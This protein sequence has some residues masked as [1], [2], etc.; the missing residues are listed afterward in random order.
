MRFFTTFSLFGALV[1][2]LPALSPEHIEAIR[3][4]NL[5][6]DSTRALETRQS[7]NVRN[8]LQAGGMCPPVI[9][10]WARGSTEEGNMVCDLEHRTV[11]NPLNLH[12]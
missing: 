8:E 1:A 4:W 3:S 5:V 9:L 7:S 2:A 12:A 11:I 10:I 6:A